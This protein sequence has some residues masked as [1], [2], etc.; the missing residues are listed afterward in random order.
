MSDYQRPVA[1]L[2]LGSNFLNHN[3]YDTS[4]H[5]DFVAHSL[6]VRPC[7]DEDYTAGVK[8]MAKIRDG[9]STPALSQTE[10][11]LALEAFVMMG[12]EDKCAQAIHLYKQRCPSTMH[13]EIPKSL[14]YTIL[15]GTLPSLKQTALWIALR[16]QHG[17]MLRG[18][19]TYLSSTSHEILEK[20]LYASSLAVCRFPKSK[21]VHLDV[22]ELALQDLPPCPPR[23]TRVN[24]WLPWF[25]PSTDLPTFVKSG[26]TS[27]IALGLT[28]FE[29][30]TPL[31]EKRAD[32]GHLTL[33]QVKTQHFSG[34]DKH[35]EALTS[36][37]E[38]HGAPLYYRD[39][40]AKLPPSFEEELRDEVKLEDALYGFLT[41]YS[42]YV[43]CKSKEDSIP[44][45]EEIVF[46]NCCRKL[47]KGMRYQLAILLNPKRMGEYAVHLPTL[48]DK[49]HPLLCFAHPWFDEWKEE[50]KSMEASGV[51]NDENLQAVIMARVAGI[52]DYLFEYVLQNGHAFYKQV[53]SLV[54]ASL[55]SLSR[56]SIQRLHILTVLE[57]YM[58]GMISQDDHFAAVL[59]V[60]RFMTETSWHAPTHRETY[61][62]ETKKDD[63]DDDSVAPSPPPFALSLTHEP[64]SQALI[65]FDDHSSSSILSDMSVIAKR[66]GLGSQ[67]DVHFRPEKPINPDGYL[68]GYI[69]ILCQWALQPKCYPQRFMRKDF[70]RFVVRQGVSEEIEGLGPLIL[71]P[72]IFLDIHSPSFL[73]VLFERS[74]D[75]NFHPIVGPQ[76]LYLPLPSESYEHPEET[77][78]FER[79]LQI[80]M[81]SCAITLFNSLKLHEKRRSHITVVDTMALSGF[82]MRKFA[83]HLGSAIGRLSSGDSILWYGGELS[84]EMDPWTSLREEADIM[85]YS[86]RLMEDWR[87]RNIKPD[88]IPLAS[89]APIVDPA[90]Q[91]AIADRWEY[92]SDE[93]F[94]DS[95]QAWNEV[96]NETLGEDVKKEQKRISLIQQKKMGILDDFDNPADPKP[97]E[98]L[99]TLETIREEPRLEDEEE[100]VKEAKRRVHRFATSSKEFQGKRVKMADLPCL[101]SGMKSPEKPSPMDTKKQ[102]LLSLIHPYDVDTWDSEAYFDI[103][104]RVIPGTREL[105][106]SLSFHK[107]SIGL[108]RVPGLRDQI[109]W[110]QKTDS[111]RFGHPLVMWQLISK[112]MWHNIDSFIAK[113][114]DRKYYIALSYKKTGVTWIERFL[115]ITNLTALPKKVFYQ[116]SNP[117]GGAYKAF[118]SYRK[119]LYWIFLPRLAGYI[120]ELPCMGWYSDQTGHNDRL[121]PLNWNI[122]PVNETLK[123]KSLT[124]F[125]FGKAFDDEAID[126][127]FRGVFGEEVNQ[128]RFHGMATHARRL[129]QKCEKDLTEF[130]IPIDA[131][132]LS[133][134]NEIVEKSSHMEAIGPMTRARAKS[135]SKE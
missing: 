95:T 48:E 61:A 82:S 22:V 23:T 43:A 75:S 124:E 56:S 47:W 126:T 118:K 134:Y 130:S 116:T 46:G 9:T 70:R 129:F 109:Y 103:K 57:C 89:T 41:F 113:A 90:R 53:A 111:K 81:H 54:W 104:E 1:Y 115:K 51:L 12:A 66:L 120:P 28:F 112:I 106:L 40:K 84:F 44:E 30:C 131:S 71:D 91:K 32:T 17:E 29:R 60:I 87:K 100:R 15:H 102:R 13:Q 121:L 62:H 108:I 36:A 97:K 63:K 68:H 7:T 99:T 122:H 88:P 18:L 67:V 133:T 107:P 76:L 58:R 86:E 8:L 59:S 98:T 64:P 6:H 5:A 77:R 38:E 50:F 16:M 74:W 55:F 27:Y 2:P 14:S 105:N 72:G 21:Q 93:D 117:F 65:A 135:R 83:T 25:D 114:S 10:I 26:A 128:K 101:P 11:L 45:G 31:L 125:F 49:H 96:A 39:S 33:S 19:G 20:C 42:Y 127:I 4:T 80:G 34:S 37:S 24:Y 132:A 78:M 92:D 35:L 3:E 94:F 73:S 119:N 85:A 110:V 79:Q 123:P 52:G 69:D